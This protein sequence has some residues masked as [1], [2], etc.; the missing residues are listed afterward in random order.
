MFVAP[1]ESFAVPGVTVDAPRRLPDPL[2]LP[3]IHAADEKCAR[4]HLDRLIHEYADP[5]I[6]AAVRRYHYG[7]LQAQRGRTDV[8]GADLRSETI[9]QLLLRVTATRNAGACPIANFRSYVKVTARHVCW[10]HRRKAQ[11]EKPGALMDCGEDMLSC[12]AVTDPVD[13]SGLV[14]QRNLLRAVW[15]E[16]R[17]LPGTQQAALLLNF[18]DADGSNAL[19]LLALCA[20]TPPDEIARTL[21]VASEN[22]AAFL[23]HLPLED[24]AIAAR[25]HLTAREVINLRVAARRRLKRR[26]R[27]W[28]DSVA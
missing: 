27:A 2:L 21:G 24:S 4:T 3:F 7:E 18:R 5:I 9:Q 16:I 14:M 25:L 19:P 28:F 10:Q 23:E 17:T 22:L 6:A 8:E 20:V 12:G 11:R 15:A 1:I 13:V 26:L